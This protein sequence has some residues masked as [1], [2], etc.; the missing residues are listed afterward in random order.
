VSRVLWAMV[1]NRRIAVVVGSA[2][3]CVLAV[4]ACAGGKSVQSVAMRHEQIAVVPDLEAGEAAWCTV[5]ES[6]FACQEGAMHAPV[7]TE[8]WG[9]A[10]PPPEWSGDAVVTSKVAS[11]RIGSWTGP[12]RR[13]PELPEGMRVVSV[14][15]RE[16]K[17]VT[18]RRL[19]S[20]RPHFTPLDKAGRLV[21]LGREQRRRF[22]L[23]TEAVDAAGG[24]AGHPCGIQAPALPGL[25]P[26]RAV[27]AT[28]VT[29][30]T[31]PLSELLVSCANTTYS[32]DGRELTAAILLDASHPGGASPPPL[33]GMR[34]L[35]R[36]TRTYVAPGI[37][38][39]L[40]ARRFP[41]LWLVVAGGTNEQ[42]YRL[43]EDLHASFISS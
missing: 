12:T 7:I 37:Q 5:D 17:G 42:R 1:G 24:G 43:L 25:R 10:A 40:L 13:E 41:N 23:P 36:K 39:S 3:V 38:G 26:T 9:A 19:L 32:R 8:S 2:V 29:P 28:T 22:K 21:G 16:P 30:Y 15:I 20:R 35:R 14:T 27:V 33:P 6:G 18:G 4:A 31:G 34:L 11:V